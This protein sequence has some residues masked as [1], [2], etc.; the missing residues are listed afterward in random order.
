MNDKFDQWAKGLAQS[1]TRRQ[2]LKK[3]GVGLAVTG[4]AALGLASRAKAAQ[5][6]CK[7]S[8]KPCHSGSECCSGYCLGSYG[9]YKGNNK[10]TCY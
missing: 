5:G 2:A 6:G 3:F 4:L 10:G 1:T 9:K 7:A 8:G